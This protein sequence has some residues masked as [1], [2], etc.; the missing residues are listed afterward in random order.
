MQSVRTNK[1]AKKWAICS[2]V[3]GVI[4]VAVCVFLTIVGYA[5]GFGIAF[6]A[7]NNI[8]TDFPPTST[9]MH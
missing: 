5:V 3:S 4:I 8:R 9:P 7:S 1:S 2:I 6:S